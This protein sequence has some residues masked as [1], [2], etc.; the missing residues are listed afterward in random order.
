VLKTS[1][2]KIAQSV[3]EVRIDIKVNTLSEN[4]V[5]TALVGTVRKV[6]RGS[7]E[8]KNLH[9]L[10]YP[11]MGTR[12]AAIDRL[13]RDYQWNPPTIAKC[14][15]HPTVLMISR[16]RDIARRR[17]ERKPGGFRLYVGTKDVLPGTSLD[18]FVYED[19]II[20]LIAGA[21][22]GALEINRKPM[23]EKG[24]PTDNP[25]IMVNAWGVCYRSH[26]ESHHLEEHVRALLTTFPPKGNEGV[27][28]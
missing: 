26:G 17:G 28:P 4:V 15:D 6:N 25:C 10:C 9:D 18:E 5:E 2:K 1:I 13:V 14:H 19:E 3:Y 22:H 21:E 20:R 11:F 23:P 12:K 8:P 27:R 7:W 24:M 16:C